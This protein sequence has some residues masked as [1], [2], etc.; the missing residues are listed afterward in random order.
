MT[1][2]P[3]STP[4]AA[5]PLSP[6][7]EPNGV[8]DPNPEVADR[9]REMDRARETGVLPAPVRAAMAIQQESSEIL[10]GWI[11]LAVVVGFGSLY[12]L[13][14]KTFPPEAELHPIPWVLGAYAAFT[15][16]RLYLAYRRRL[17]GW[18][19]A[20]SVVADVVLL[21]GTIWSF[22][23][24]YM[25]PAAFYLKAPTVLYLFIFIAIRTLRFEPRYVLLSGFAAAL[26]WVGMVVY[27]VYL[28]GMDSPIT[29]DYVQYLTT[30]AILF[31]AEFDKIVSILAVT[32][33]LA[34]AIVRARRL[35]TLAVRESLAARE[36][37]R[38][39]ARDVADRITDLDRTVELGRGEIREAAI[40]YVDIRGFS[41]IA[42]EIPPDA[43]LALL[44]EYQHVVVPLIQSHGGSIDKFL[45]DGIMATFG[46]TRTGGTPHA[47]ALRAV[48]AVTAAAETW[49]RR[50]DS[51]GLP[52]PLVGAAVAAGPVVFGAIGDDTRLE[53]T[54]IGAAVNLAAKLEKHTKA[55]R[56]RALTDRPTYERAR[57]QGYDRDVAPEMRTGREVM[58]LETPVDLVVLAR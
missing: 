12:A 34:I 51:E 49:R 5:P 47:D 20:L 19:L 14:P 22:H 38:F 33:I 13:S 50:R 23:V 40:L 28:D 3:R 8:S 44:S 45:G 43:L 55:E 35:L 16:L 37:S 54:V 56:V 32:A 4:P 6:A 26:G 58:G 48:D 42:T 21:L 25:Q 36:L 1:G 46:A 41:G 30:N 7:V 29:R 31:G 52:A 11:Q 24:Q 27:A 17:A 15:L 2:S 18:F 9:V 10:I 53:Y 39:F 57:S